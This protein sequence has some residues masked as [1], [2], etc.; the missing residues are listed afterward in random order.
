MEA[1]T[2][3]GIRVVE[4]AT[5]WVGPWAGMILANMGAQVIKVESTRAMD[6]TRSGVA[7]SQLARGLYP[8]GNPG[9]RP[10]NRHRRFVSSN[11]GKCDVTLDI[12]R[13]EGYEVLMRL[14][15]V[16]EVF[17]TNMVPTT[18]EKLGLSYDDL[19]KVKPDLVYAAASGFGTESPYRSRVVMGNTID[20]Y[21]G[22]LGLRDYGDGDSTSVSASTH[23]D[24]IGA[25]SLAFA[26]MIGLYHKRSTGRG[27]CVV[28]P[29][30]GAAMTHIGEAFVQYSMD[31]QVPRSSGNK[32]VRF[33]QGCY[34]CAGNDEWVTIS[35]RTDEEWAALQR[36]LGNPL[37]LQRAE[38]SD[39]IGRLR[40]QA[41]IDHAIGAWTSTHTKQE[42]MLLLQQL[43]V[44][45]GAVYN[46]QDV[47]SDDHLRETEF[48]ETIACSEVGTHVYP[49]RPWRLS[50]SKA[51]PRSCPPGLGEHNHYV[52]GEIAGLTNQEV[53]A[54]ES[55]G[56]TGT[57]PERRSPTKQ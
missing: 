1:M 46:Y 37:E 6:M 5:G 7:T 43:C 2:L 22:M 17:I 57:T 33:V 25:A 16:S 56:I 53:E 50:S 26:V 10:W 29:I 49:G 20:A 15:R 51:A 9:E 40:N 55:L 13:P 8:D 42:S 19:I 30:V 41:S 21:S 38:L 34:P 28:V 36:A 31:G 18:V 32:D 35:V 12:T 47:Y 45:A 48:W 4:C 44:P 11:L 14:V 39:P 23:C 52:L 24:S 54:L 3:K 27:T